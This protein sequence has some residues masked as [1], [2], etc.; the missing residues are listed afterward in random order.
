MT[1]LTDNLTDTA[2]VGRRSGVALWRQIADRIRQDLALWSAE[3]DGRL[4]SEAELA[5]RF[6]VNRHT[7][8]AALS[9]LGREGVIRSERGRGTFVVQ[10]PRI[11]YPIGRRTRFSTA[12]EA[13]NS[14]GRLLLLRHARVAADTVVAEALRLPVGAE[15]VMLET[16]GM[17]EE[18]PISFATHWFD[19]TRF[20]ALPEHLDRTGSITQALAA[21]G[22]ADYV[23]RST[24]LE[25]RRAL[26]VEAT[27]LDLT[28]DGLVMVARA[29]NV[30]LHGTPIQLSETRFAADRVE[31]VVDQA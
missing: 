19:A 22:V 7:V 17:A 27:E 16:R 24:V 26:P 21:C 28:D 5:S 4:P 23:R 13:Q 25:A 1:E 3:R 18:T 29:L 11:A 8:R 14:S 31:I 12:L 6:S 30:D 10:R 2:D 15:V 20:A 9:A